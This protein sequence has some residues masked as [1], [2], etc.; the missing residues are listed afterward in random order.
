HVEEKNASAADLLRF[1][2]FLAPDA[3]PKNIIT[4]GGPH[5]GPLLKSVA[6]DPL[7]LSKAVETLRTYSLIQ[8]DPRTETLSI[9]RLAQAVLRDNMATKGKKQWK[10]RVVRAVNASHPD[11]QDLAQWD[12]CEQWLPHAQVCATWIEQ[13]DMTNP[14]ASDLLDD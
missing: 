3:I 5:L 10:Q 12:A 6:A 4:Q 9:H 11:V 1:C 7:L 8:R 14:E 2:S 13:E